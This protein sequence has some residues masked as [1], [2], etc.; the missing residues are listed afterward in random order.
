MK[1]H[2]DIE[3]T[4]EE[5]RAFFGL[6]D[7]RPLQAAVME[8]MQARTLEA[9]RRMEPE[10]VLKSWFSTG[11]SGFEQFQKAFWSNFTPR[12]ERDG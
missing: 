2:F 1:V 9:M 11:A 3:C 12:T 6:P 7:V 5:A 4:P 10:A 8:E